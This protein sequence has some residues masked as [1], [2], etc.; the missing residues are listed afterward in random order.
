MMGKNDLAGLPLVGLIGIA[1]TKQN[2]KVR[3]SQPRPRPRSTWYTSGQ[4]SSV[5]KTLGGKLAGS[6][7][8]G[9]SPTRN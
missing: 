9:S 2:L 5:L 8:K 7:P 3:S 6:T 4:W 1:T